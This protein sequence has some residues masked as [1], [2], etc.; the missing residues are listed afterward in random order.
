MLYAEV[1]HDIFGNNIVMQ[2]DQEDVNTICYDFD[3]FSLITV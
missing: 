2:I 1:K 3:L